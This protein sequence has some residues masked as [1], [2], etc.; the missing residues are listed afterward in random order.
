M[1]VKNPTEPADTSNMSG[2]TPRRMVPDIT[3]VPGQGIRRVLEPGTNVF[4][5]FVT[6]GVLKDGADLSYV[7]DKSYR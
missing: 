3:L 5:C 4:T 2:S 7:D 6:I 1:F